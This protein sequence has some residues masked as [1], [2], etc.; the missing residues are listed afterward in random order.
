MNRLKLLAA[1]MLLA[2]PIACGDEVLPPP[3]TGSI[4]GLVSIEGQGIDGISVTLSNGG[5]AITANG[6]MYRFDG[7]EAGAY[8]VTISNYPDD[9]SFNQTSAT[10]TITTDGENVTV[11]FPGTYIRTSH[12]TGTVTVENEGL[13]GVTVKLSGVSDSETLTDASGLY[14]FAGLRAGN[15]TIEISGFDDEDVAFGSTS[16]AASVAVGES[17]VVSFEGTYLRTSGIMGQVKA[18]DLPQEGITVS[19]QGRGENRSVT[20]NSA[21]QFSFDELRRGDYAVGI[22]GY[23]TDEMSFDV[24]SQSVTVA[25]GETENVPF[26]GILLRTAGIAGTVTVEGVGPIAN[27]TVTI[28]GQG[29][30]EDATTDNMGA[31]AFEGLRAGEYSVAISG[32][33]DDEYGFFHPDGSDAT[34]ATVT[35]EL[36][37]TGTVPFDGIMLRTAA[38]DGTVTVGDDDVPLPGV[39]VTVSGG[40]REEEHSRTTNNDGYFEVEELHAGTYSVSISGYDTNEFGF[41][42]P[43]VGEVTVDLRDRE[44]VAFQGELLRTAGVS[45]RVHVGG[46]GMAGVTVTL[47]GEESREG[48]TDADG[49]YA[50]SGLAAGDY[51]LTISGWDEVEYHFT[52]TADITLALDESR[53]GVNFEGRALRTATVMGSVTVEGDALPGIAVTLIRVTGATSGEVIG[54]MA[55]DENGG[56]SF[57]PL[58]AG[59]YQV[60]IAGYDDEHAF[61]ATTQSAIVMTDGTATVNFMATIIRTASVSGMVTVDDDPMAGVEVTLGGDHAPDVNTMMTGDDGGYS[62]GGLRKGDYTVSI[63]NPDADAYSFPGTSQSLNLSVGQEQT[64]ISF[65]GARLMQASISGQVHAEGDAVQGVMVTLSGDADAE[66]MTDANGEYNFPGLAGGDYKVTI[67]GWNAAAY[68]FATTETDVAGLGTDEFKIV[69]F[70]G[71]HTRTAS[72]GGMLFVDEGGANALM[73]DAGEPVLSF[74][75]LAFPVTLLGP[76]LGDITHGTANADGTYEFA[77]LRAGAYVL[78]IDVEMEVD[79]AAGTTVKDVLADLGYE[80]TGPTLIQVSVAAAEENTDNNLPFKIITQTINV[81]AVMGTPAMATETPVAGVELVLFATAEHAAAGTPMLGTATTDEMG[82]ASFDFARAMDLGPGGQGND[83]LVYA[84]V[85]DEGHA[86]LELS[87]NR[88]IEIQYV[89]IDRV[90]DAEAAARLVNV[91]V[92]FQWW[93]KSDA[94][95]RDGNAFLEGWAANH[96]EATD[97]AGHSS[98]SG[99]LS[100]AD[101]IAGMQYEVKLAEAQDDE[102]T[103]GEQWEQSAALAHEHNPLLLSADNEA[104]DND[105]G[106]IYVTWT[107]QTLVLG[108]YREA[109]DVDGF[110]GY[111]SGLYGGDHRPHGDVGSIRILALDG[112][113]RYADYEWDHDADAATDDV[114]A[115]DFDMEDGLISFSGIGATDSITIRFQVGDDR[116][117]VTAATDGDINPWGSDLGVG[118]TVGAFGDQSGGVPEVRLCMA[119]VID[120]SDDWCATY[121]YQWTNGE[122]S[123]EF[124]ARLDDSYANYDIDSLDVEMTVTLTSETSNHGAAND[125]AMTVDAFSFD[126]LQDGTYTLTTASDRYTVDNAPCDDVL[127]IF[128]DEENET[129]GVMDDCDFNVT[130]NDPPASGLHIR[131]YVGN[132]AN[133]NQR[134]LGS[135]EVRAGIELE[136]GRFNTDSAKYFSTGVTTTTDANGYY[137]FDNLHELGMYSVTVMGTDDYQGVRNTDDADDP[138]TQ[139]AEGLVAAEQGV[140]AGVDL[141]RWDMKNH[142]AVNQDVKNGDE[143]GSPNLVNFALVYIGGI[144]G[145]VNVLGGS[146]SGAHVVAYRCTGADAAAGCAAD[147][148]DR[149]MAESVYSGADG[150]YTLPGLKEG[151]YTVMIDDRSGEFSVPLADSLGNPDDDGAATDS[152]ATSM[153]AEL[154]GPDPNRSLGPLHVYRN[155]LQRVISV[156]EDNIDLIGY[157]HGSDDASYGAVDTITSAGFAVADDGGN[158]GTASFDGGVAW[159][160]SDVT[161][162]ITNP[163]VTNGTT[164]AFEDCSNNVCT[165]EGDTT[166]A[167]ADG[168]DSTNVIVFMATAANG[169]NDTRYATAVTVKAPIGNTLEAADFT[170]GTGGDAT[171]GFTLSISNTSDIVKI[172]LDGT[173]EGEGLTCRQSVAVTA[174]DDAVDPQVTGGGGTEGCF[175]EYDLS[176]GEYTLT[177]TSEDGRTREQT[178]TITST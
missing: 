104:A 127:H 111:Q 115:S 150:A 17:K 4:D 78:N 30:S 54:A 113:N 25:Y 152:V 124:N 155:S 72:I 129:A 40:P 43:T 174:G 117:V 135:H 38:I 102:A 37:S 70:E 106:P 98:Y 93:V 15:Y 175:A 53:T 1:A 83:H 58:L 14:A 63:T 16:S 160:M 85:T 131:G 10:A 118:M 121:G 36:Q 65:A 6:G 92:N 112:D 132:D 122:V 71:M 20:T 130:D 50:F 13:P 48:M 140:P 144:E 142:A 168:V 137:T 154:R 11:N 119:S 114:T 103:G 57:G 55:T 177:V 62:F 2:V 151:Y 156:S 64:G 143:A 26:E 125:Q 66:D 49:Q 91:Q 133:E 76:D 138:L 67:A 31:Y 18:D 80:Y 88:D 109:D 159:S 12:I 167:A 126:D 68:E 47:T 171:A 9:A 123:G 44:T 73:H 165:L 39:M 42:N 89:A 96:G 134:F 82:V 34:S 146:K 90:S 75:N 79:A 19:L 157:K 86:D 170:P 21:G 69:D 56:Y 3:P 46:M 166:D 141:P 5:S 101:A 100:V 7:V 52:P 41:S 23:D 153:N 116:K 110:T 163:A 178:L 27:V 87:D 164:I 28:S 61:A 29:E 22:S 136:L 145:T 35:V 32:F 149:T 108:F 176:A 105:L 120:M 169:Y 97:G 148:A 8:T 77:G 74:D 60:M 107:T 81:E 45:G 161:L 172:L 84:R 147:E 128:Y 59:A 162:L 139:M 51:T 99:R 33:D 94:D 158:G 95:A 24:T 173:G